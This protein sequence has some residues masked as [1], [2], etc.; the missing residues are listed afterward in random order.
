MGQ[1]VRV[2][3]AQMQYG[4]IYENV[5]HFRDDSVT[6][7]PTSIKGYIETHWIPAIKG[8][9]ASSVQYKTIYVRDIS[10]A[11]TPTYNYPIAINGGGGTVMNCWGPAAA[12]YSI[13]TAVGGPHGR[14]RFYVSGWY[15]GNIYEGKFQV[16]VLGYFQATAN[17]LIAKFIT[18][19][20][21]VGPLHLVVCPR[22]NPSA[23]NY[24]TN[25]VVKSIPGVVRRRN[26]GVG[27]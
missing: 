21:L 4:Q 14:G 10:T 24:A 20:T 3:I 16:D 18:A 19:G 22:L 8:Q 5:I 11:G 23:F 12:V 6:Y 27:N 9:Q 7:D 1:L 26:I 25:I 13:Q 2:T 15:V 17:T